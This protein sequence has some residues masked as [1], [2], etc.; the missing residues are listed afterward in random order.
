MIYILLLTRTRTRTPRGRRPHC[1]GRRTLSEA[2]GAHS[3]TKLRLPA[4]L[5]R[6][7]QCTSLS[8]PRRHP[9]IL[10]PLAYAPERRLPSKRPPPVDASL[11]IAPA[12]GSTAFWRN[13]ADVGSKGPQ[14]AGASGCM[15][16]T[17]ARRDMQDW[18][19]ALDW[20]NKAEAHL[21]LP[22]RALK[23]PIATLLAPAARPGTAWH[24]LR[25][26]LP[27]VPSRMLVCAAT[28]DIAASI[29]RPGRNTGCRSGR[30]SESTLAA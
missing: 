21:R 25:F 19:C 4:L 8:P 29:A 3:N 14:V 9:R 23:Q 17:T 27:A 28:P 24:G 26:C 1:S 7:A 12:P 5:R 18:T 15:Q 11:A 16:L 20:P 6:R 30:S 2:R 13:T 22:Q 10:T